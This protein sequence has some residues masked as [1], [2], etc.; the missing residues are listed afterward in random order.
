MGDYMMWGLALLAAAALLVVVEVFVPSGG[1]IA[2]T[3]GVT[4]IA[5][6]V[7]MFLD[8]W[9][10]GLVGILIVLVLGPAVVAFALRIWP[11]T[12]MGRRILRADQDE[13]A[14][15][16]RAMEEERERREKLALVGA[17]GVALTELRPV[18][19]VEIEGRRYD[20]LAETSII[21]AGSR[22]KVSRIEGV[23]VRVRGLA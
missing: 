8:G 10:T 3:A 12:P 4:A 19:V 18:G 13:A 5:A 21:D 20:A 17:E 9:R 6:V 23:Q 14:A 7:V 16:T 22:V 11:S 2:V 1:I 15:A